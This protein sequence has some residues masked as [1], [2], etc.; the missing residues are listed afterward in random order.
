MLE[1]KVKPGE[2]YI[3]LTLLEYYSHLVCRSLLF[4]HQYR[5]IQ[6]T[7]PAPCQRRSCRDVSKK[8]GSFATDIEKYVLW[9]AGNICP[10]VLFN[11]ID[12]LYQVDLI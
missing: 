11:F 3:S 1:S 4:C 5:S 8:K 12:I 9:G 2:T 6:T 10:L 7:D